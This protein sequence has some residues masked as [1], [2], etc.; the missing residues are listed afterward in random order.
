MAGPQKNSLV[1]AT[2]EAIH[3]RGLLQGIGAEMQKPIFVDNQ[4]CLALSKRSI[5]DGKFEDLALKLRFVRELEDKGEPN[6]K[7]SQTDHM[8]AD[9]FAKGLGK[10]NY[11]NF[12]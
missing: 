5:H 7:C 6:L 8:I 11:V 3:L 9:A 2:K 10:I 1:E 12:A 4:T